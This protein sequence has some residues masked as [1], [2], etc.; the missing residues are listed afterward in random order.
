MFVVS[1]FIIIYSRHCDIYGPQV[2]GV[3]L[4]ILFIVNEQPK[5]ITKAEIEP[6]TSSGYFTYCIKIYLAIHY[7]T[8][9]YVSIG[10]Q[11]FSYQDNDD[12]MLYA[13][14]SIL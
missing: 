9:E 13:V 6:K 11:K 4:L 3:R 10:W 7:Y 1:K 2:P 12:F 14:A 5:S 8:E